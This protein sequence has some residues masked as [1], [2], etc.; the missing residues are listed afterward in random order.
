MKTRPVCMDKGKQISMC[1]AK[2]HCRLLGCP[3]L[4]RFAER[5]GGSEGKIVY[6][7]DF[8]LVNIANPGMFSAGDGR[9]L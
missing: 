5:K 9:Q 4:A 1:T 8:G 2:G 3:F 6:S 7:N